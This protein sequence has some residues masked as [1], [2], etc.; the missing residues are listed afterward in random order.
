MD[1]PQIHVLLLE[2]NLA[3]VVMLEAALEQIACFTFQV[4][5][6]EQL[7]QGLGSLSLRPYDLVL[8]DLGLPD[9][10]GLATFTRLHAQNPEAPVV[11]LSGIQDEDLAAE[12]VR[13]G[14][15]DYLVKGHAGGE[16]LGRAIRYAIERHQ[17]QAQLRTSEQ[18]F[19]ALIEHSADAVATLDAD[20]I[21]LYQSPSA[22]RM[23]GYQPDEMIGAS[24]F[25]FLHPDD[26][27]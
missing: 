5:V 25:I 17:L 16:V 10:Q 23:L 2:D 22:L 6:V 13:A 19:R 14:A 12:A 26:L 3:D 7:S 8:L 15:Q 9:S 21:I 20:G 4:T 24:A 11:V 18:H 27:A 1:K